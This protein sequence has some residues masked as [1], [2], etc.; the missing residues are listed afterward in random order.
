MSSPSSGTVV[1]NDLLEVYDEPLH[2][3]KQRD[4]DRLEKEPVQTVTL[5]TCTTRGKDAEQM[6]ALIAEYHIG[7]KATKMETIRCRAVEGIVYVLQ[8]TS[9]ACVVRV[10]LLSPLAR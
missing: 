7:V 10:F 4:H 9:C 6:D 5:Q 8:C 3:T 1:I 2:P